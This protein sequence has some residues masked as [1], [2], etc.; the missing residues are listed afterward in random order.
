[1]KQNNNHPDDTTKQNDDY[2]M[3]HTKYL[4][5][6]EPFFGI[7]LKV[8]WLSTNHYPQGSLEEGKSQKVGEKD[9]FT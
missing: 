1:M 7:I 6:S 3:A 8:D 2:E 9:R 5:Y 4:V